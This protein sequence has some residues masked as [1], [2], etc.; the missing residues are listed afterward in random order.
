ME[1]VPW[2]DP[3]AVQASGEANYSDCLANGAEVIDAPATTV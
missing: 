1:A 2:A 3:F